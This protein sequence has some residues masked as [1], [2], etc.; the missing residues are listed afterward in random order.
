[1]AAPF[2]ILAVA[3]FCCAGLT[4]FLTLPFN[5]AILV[6]AQ[7]D[8][9]K[10]RRK[11]MDPE[12]HDALVVARYQALAGIVIAVIWLVLL[13]IRCVVFSGE[14]YGLLPSGN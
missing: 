14:R 8:L 12:G 6:M 9:D 7:N 2:F 13:G 5:I 3:S 4:A 10:I 11:I 1:M